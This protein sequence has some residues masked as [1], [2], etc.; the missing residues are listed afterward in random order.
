MFGFLMFLFVVLCAFLA[1]FILIQ[2]GKG[3][4]GL[5]SLGGSGQLLFGGSGGQNFFEKATWIMGGVF[6]LGALGLS[7]IKSHE[8]RESRLQGFVV[9]QPAKN[10]PANQPVEDTTPQDIPEQSA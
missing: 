3:D 10:M 7:I 9:S 8:T 2:P 1:L 4:M 6:M 5:G